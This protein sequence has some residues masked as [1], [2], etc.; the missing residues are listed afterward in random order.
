MHTARWDHGADLAGKRVAVIGTGASAVQVIPSIAPEVE[1]LTVFQRT[2]IWCLPKPDAELS[3]VV[4]WCAAATFRARAASRASL[5]Q[6]FVEVT[7]PL[8]G[9]LQRDHPARSSSAKASAAGTCATR[10]TIPRSATSSPRAT[11]S[12]CKRPELLQRVPADL[13]PRQRPPRDRRRSTRSRRP[14]SA[15]S[16][17]VEHEID[18]LVL[19]TGF[20]VFE[21]G[22]M[23]PFP[24]L[25][26]DGVDL[27][28]WWDENRFQAYE[29]VSVPGFPNMFTILGPY[30][31]NGASYFHL[32]ET[33]MRHIT[34][35][36]RR[37]REIGATR[38]EISREAND[39]YWKSMLA[40][41]GNQIFFRD[42]CATANSYYFDRA[43][44]RT[45]PRRARASRRC[46][47]APASTSTTTAS[48]ARRLRSRH[49]H[50]NAGG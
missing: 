14:A 22:N 19:A 48:S 16:D 36:L 15:P 42:T 3:G 10:S 39:R 12:G 24:V 9:P 28:E 38:V 44:R 25:G 1:H 34:R 29:G 35:C 26:V 31:Y 21:A 7:F 8:A 37:A 5:S 6:A 27:E 18:V 50:R 2:P 41:R 33:Q 11:A 32:I 43:R 49:D 20:K 30:G 45:V 46:G 4:G 23:P 17:G 40:R 13:Q 47:E